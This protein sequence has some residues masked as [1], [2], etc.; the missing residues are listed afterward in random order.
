MLHPGPSARAASAAATAT[1][2]PFFA[3]VQD[4]LT[5]LFEFIGSER[6]TFL[7]NGEKY[8]S[9]VAEAILVSP[10]VSEAL[11]QDST[12][13]TFII[14]GSD[15]LSSD[16]NTI[17]EIV[18]SRDG[19]CFAA[20]HEMSLLS[21]GKQIGNCALSFAFLQHLKSRL[22]SKCE[23]QTSDLIEVH[24]RNSNNLLSCS[25]T[26]RYCASHFC[27][28]S[29][30][31]LRCLDKGIL[32][33]LLSSD[34]LRVKNEDELLNTLIELGPD[35]LEFWNHIEVRFLSDSG[36][37]CFVTKLP[38][39]SLSED[40]W[41]QFVSI[42]SYSESKSS[43]YYRFATPSRLF[44]SLIVSSFPSVLRELTDERWDLLYRGSR[45]G[46]TSNVFH[47]KCDTI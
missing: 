25:D 2:L 36:L 35:Y 17:L 26:I 19:I 14:S 28:Y 33:A 46:Y 29:V 21:I 12:I 11:K 8:D 3:V 47:A 7:V 15:I 32:H 38:F 34:D 9:T 18:R 20:D 43:H 5:R 4:G 6:F 31:E 13:R 42:L 39:C 41:S 22:E 27:M 40:I 37:A 24:L 44:D 16:F 45:D 10:S 1:L 23:I 30:D